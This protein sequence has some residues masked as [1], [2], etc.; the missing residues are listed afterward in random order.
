M[1]ILKFKNFK[2]NF[3]LTY[4][5]SFLSSFYLIYFGFSQLNRTPSYYFLFTNCVIN[6]LV[7]YNLSN[8]KRNYSLKNIVNIF[9]FIFFGVS[10]IFQINDGFYI[11]GTHLK[12]YEIIISN[13][14]IIIIIIIINLITKPS[15]NQSNSENVHKTFNSRIKEIRYYL[16]FKGHFFLFFI[17]VISFYVLFSFYNFSIINF[18]YRSGDSDNSFNGG[19]VSYL[20]CSYF[21]RPFIFNLFV[22]YFFCK[23]KSIFLFLIIAI[24]AIIAVFPTGVPRF[25][26]AT[27]FLTFFCLL[28]NY[29][30]KF[31]VS[32]FL[33]VIVGLIF[34]FPFFDIFRVLNASN[35]LVDYEFNFDLQSGNF[36]AFGMY[37]LALNRCPILYGSN[38]LT[39]LLFFVPRSIWVNKGIGSG[40]LVSDKLNLEFDNVSM[41]L[42]AEGY[43]AF[44]YLGI[45]LVVFILC[46]YI[47]W[48]DDFFYNYILSNKI[49]NPM[50]LIL[51]LNLLFLLF[52]MM[53]GDLLSS[54]AYL[55]GITSAN[56]F[57]H[58]IMRFFKYSNA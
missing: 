30:T 33:I 17:V 46:K 56:I 22:L 49:Q 58:V 44:G 42:F 38:I 32:L 26:A 34:I 16:P 8:I 51:Y 18:I 48:L 24:I 28:I 10:P 53:R 52:F 6:L 41:P 5:L 19:Q 29:Y 45:L 15:R 31:D 57:I 20:I 13:V 25:F 43:L 2:I 12:E 9:I 4:I 54:F 40:A 3:K 21:I 50:L 23:N 36:D 27:M 1:I 11:W 14:S 7:L 39:A 35:S 55:I 47:N 37:T